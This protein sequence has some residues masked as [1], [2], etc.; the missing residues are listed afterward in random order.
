MS[1]FMLMIDV[2]NDWIRTYPDHCR[3][4]IKVKGIPISH[5]SVRLKCKEKYKDCEYRTFLSDHDSIDEL[6]N[7]LKDKNLIL[8]NIRN[9][10]KHITYI[11]QQIMSN[12]AKITFYDE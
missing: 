6:M 3:N 8:L 12:N 2:Y 9:N 11:C 7:I 10:S 5:N 4:D 1:E